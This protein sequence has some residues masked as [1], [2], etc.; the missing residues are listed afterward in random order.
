MMR[1]AGRGACAALP[2]RGGLPGTYL[3]AGRVIQTD[4]LCEAGTGQQG[5]DRGQTPPSRRARFSAA[6]RTYL[7][8]VPDPPGHKTSLFCR[9]ESVACART[10]AELCTTFHDSADALTSQRQLMRKGFSSGHIEPCRLR[11]ADF[12]TAFLFGHVHIDQFWLGESM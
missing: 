1:R 2:G 3:P 10:Y 9:K 6:T 8:S 5:K 4:R 7:A 11:G 12:C